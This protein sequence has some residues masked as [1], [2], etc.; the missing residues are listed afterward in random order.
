MTGAKDPDEFILKYGPERFQKL[1]DNSI[2]YAEYKINRLKLNY[3]LEDT[4]QKIQFLTKMAEILSKIDNNIERDIYVDKYS[5]ELGVGKE[6]I[7]AEI[8]KKTLR[9]TVQK[10]PRDF[11]S[12]NL[13]QQKGTIPY[14][15]SVNEDMI[16][17]LLAQKKENIFYKLK[18]N[19]PLSLIQDETKKNIIV[20]LY[21]LY[22]TGNINNREVDS[23]CETEEEFNTMTGILMNE[24]RKEDTDKVLIE[25]IK[26]FQLENLKNKKQALMQELAKVSTNEERE[27]IAIEL[28]EINNQLGQLMIR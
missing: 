11:I 23:V 9:N 17:F 10:K 27:S 21:D 20:K 28:N 8:E 26:S 13:L 24:N 19:I 18:E 16:I 4:T 5:K 15:T 12:Q 2:S 3:H 25:V 7:L 6:A 14:T 22:E 1:M